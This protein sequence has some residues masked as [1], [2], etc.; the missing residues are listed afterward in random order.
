MEGS[1]EESFPR[2]I[3]KYFLHGMLFS[4]ISLGLSFVLAFVL[5]VLVAVGLWIGLI[6]GFALLMFMFAGI[7]VFLMA[8]LWDIWV[9]ADFM[10]LLFHGILLTIALI[11][12][13]LP[14]FIVNRFVSGPVITITVFIVYCFIDGI[15]A[16]GVGMIWEEDED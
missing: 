8:R 1:W 3:A 12:V 11:L 4:V 13:S 5:V 9:K 15:V 10:S 14:V 7:N 6:I 16:Q 2:L